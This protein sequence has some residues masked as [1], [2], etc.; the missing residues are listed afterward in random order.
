[1]G[2]SKTDSNDRLSIIFKELGITEKSMDHDLAILKE[3]YEK[4]AHLP[5]IPVEFENEIKLWIQHLLIATKNSIERVKVSI[6]SYMY[7][8]TDYPQ[9]FDSKLIKDTMH[10]EYYNACTVVTLPKLTN[11]HQMVFYWSLNSSNP[12]MLNVIYF[13]QRFRMVLDY[14]IKMSTEFFGFHSIMDMA[15]Y[16]M[17]HV[18]HLDLMLLK[19]V[20]SNG[21]KSY[22]LRINYL[23]VI[24]P[25]TFIEYCFN[26]L[27]PFI[28]KKIM[29]RVLVHKSVQELQNYISP[30]DVL[31]TQ[32]GGTGGDLEDIKRE[33][34]KRFETTTRLLDSDVFVVNKSLKPEDSPNR[35]RNVEAVLSSEE[36]GPNGS[37]RK[38]CV[39]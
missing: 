6:E 21:Q 34:D 37:F 25:P 38:L 29:S 5:P 3:W 35:I 12:A 10:N 7:T 32:L 17:A 18:S 20:L 27:R 39:D 1:M 16:K 23:H 11:T 36:F 14:H 13:A 31:P 15:N 28:S 33:W 19:R 8:R 2:I 24:N 4:Q 26:V 9:L 30:A 22:P